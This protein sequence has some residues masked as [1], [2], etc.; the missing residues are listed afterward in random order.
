MFETDFHAFVKLKN[1]VSHNPCLSAEML[2]KSVAAGVVMFCVGW[3]CR[4]VAVGCVRDGSGNPFC[5]VGL[6]GWAKRLQRTARPFGAL[7]LRQR[8]TPKIFMRLP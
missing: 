4:C 5:G 6:A 1:E 7:P 3:L 2:L 8:E